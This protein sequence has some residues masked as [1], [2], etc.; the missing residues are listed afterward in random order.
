MIRKALSAFLSLSVCVPAHAE[1]FISP[2]S[3]PRIVESVRL[4]DSLYIDAKYMPKGA[5]LPDEAMVLTIED[6]AVL[7]AE[8]ET[9]SEACNRRLEALRSAHSQALE[10]S[11]ARCDARSASCKTALEQ[12]LDKQKVLTLTLDE[13]RENLKFHKWLNVGLLASGLVLTGIL[14]YRN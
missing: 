3:L 6:F 8:A 9:Y 10:D 5:V 2:E 13:N 12:A 11:Q 4:S 7:Q 1:P 14:V